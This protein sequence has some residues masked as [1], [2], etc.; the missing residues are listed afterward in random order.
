MVVQFSL[1]TPAVTNSHVTAE[2]IGSL[3]LVCVLSN[4]LLITTPCMNVLCD[5]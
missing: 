2:Q 4:V 5:K 1:L 3:H